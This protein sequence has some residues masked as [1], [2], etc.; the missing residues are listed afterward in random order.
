MSGSKA[1]LEEELRLAVEA[2]VRLR[3]ILSLP[4]FER[5]RLLVELT[6]IVVETV[7]ALIYSAQHNRGAEFRMDLPARAAKALEALS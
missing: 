6:A 2:E 4:E 5:D 7:P 3:R 1:R